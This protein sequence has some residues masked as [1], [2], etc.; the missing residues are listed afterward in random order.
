MQSTH[1]SSHF[2]DTQDLLD[3]VHRSRG[4]EVNESLFD[5][6]PADVRQHFEAEAPR[7]RE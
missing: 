4:I 1:E 5:N 3:D 2:P 7:H 6:L